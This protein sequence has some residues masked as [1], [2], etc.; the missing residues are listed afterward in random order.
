[1]GIARFNAQKIVS[2]MSNERGHVKQRQKESN[3]EHRRLSLTPSMPRP[4]IFL[5]LPSRIICSVLSLRTIFCVQFDIT[6][7][8]MWHPMQGLHSH[9]GLHE[10]K[11]TYHDLPVHRVRFRKFLSKLKLP[12]LVM[13]CSLQGGRTCTKGK[14]VERTSGLRFVLGDFWDGLWKWCFAFKWML[15]RGEN[16]I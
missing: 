7:S 11:T 15:S 1:M 16:P 6:C 2:K 10:G 5:Q 8:F 4:V 13:H 9:S 14:V 12:S 3:P